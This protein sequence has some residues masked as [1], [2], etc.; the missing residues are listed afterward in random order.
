MGKE[1]TPRPFW[2]GGFLSLVEGEHD[3]S[4]D[5]LLIL[6][7]HRSADEEDVHRPLDIVSR[8]LAGQVICPDDKGRDLV[9]LVDV[10]TAIIT[11][12]ERH[13]KTMINIDSEGHMG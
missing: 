12:T 10:H 7:G 6:L 4:F 2:A 3:P 8:G 1:I 13:V 5:P 11:R 9:N